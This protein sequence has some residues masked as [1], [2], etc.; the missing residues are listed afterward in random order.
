MRR[1]AVQ[2]AGLALVGD[3]VQLDIV[4]PDP[5]AIGDDD[6]FQGGAVL[7]A[8]PTR[9]LEVE[10]A[11]GLDHAPAIGA[12]GVLLK[13]GAEGVQALEVTAQPFLAT[14]RRLADEG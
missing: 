9:A 14:R 1:C 8:E 7:P 11:L 10:G 12:E 5:A 4:Q 13:L 3:L 6:L 2:G